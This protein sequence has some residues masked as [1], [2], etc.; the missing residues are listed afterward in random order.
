MTETSQ[1]QKRRRAERAGRWA[2][3]F[4]AFFLVL[5]GFRILVLRHKARAGEVDIVARRRNLLAFVEVKSRKDLDTAVAAVTFR[6]RRRIE[7]AAEDFLA[8][9]PQYA[10]A[11]MRFDILAVSGWRFRYAPDAWR[12]GQ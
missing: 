2:E 4:A 5:R 6:N 9:R 11:T 1:I 12:Y 7:K 10:N 8:R 3:Y